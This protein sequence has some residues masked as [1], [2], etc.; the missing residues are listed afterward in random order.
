M[1]KVYLQYAEITTEISGLE[2]ELSEKKRAIKEIRDELTSYD[3]GRYGLDL[4][5]HA[6]TNISNRL[7]ELASESSVIYSDVYNKENPNKSLLWPSNLKAFIIS[8]I[9]SCKEDGRE[10]ESKNTSG[11]KEYHFDIEIKKW[12][13]DKDVLVFT[14]IV[15]SNMIK[16]GYFNWIERKK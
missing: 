5:A 11:G 3:N 14:A 8:I 7:S 2:F 10:K 15:E 13:T 1:N 12:S 16:T 6:F 4:T 9:A